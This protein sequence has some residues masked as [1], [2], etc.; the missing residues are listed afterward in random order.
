MSCHEVR[1]QFHAYLDGDL[2]P[3]DTERIASHLSTCVECA[4]RFADL[5]AFERS[6]R[7]AIRSE[8]PSAELRSQLARALRRVAPS[9]RAPGTK[10]QVFRTP[11]LAAAAA[12]V[13]L[14]VIVIVSWEQSDN[15]TPGPMVLA[16]A[17]VDELKSFIDSE[18]PLDLVSVDRTAAQHWLAERV[19]F[20]VPA[21]PGAADADLKGARLCFFLGRRV[22]AYMYDA[23]DHPVSLYIMADAGLAMPEDMVVGARPAPVATEITKGFAHILWARDGLVFSLVSDLPIERLMPLADGL[24][25]APARHETGT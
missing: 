19:D 11:R 5:S 6:V 23:H 21:A 24:S 4:A 18:R 1:T 13:A 15:E 9:Q 12:L 7:D 16:E 20:S 8:Q 10:R 2:A 14:L 22:A 17:P 3:R 25:A